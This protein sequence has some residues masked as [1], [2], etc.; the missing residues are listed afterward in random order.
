MEQLPALGTAIS[1]VAPNTFAIY[2]PLLVKNGSAITSTPRKSF[3][4]GPHPRQELDVY[5][6][7]LSAT[8]NDSF[9]SPILIFFY[10]GGFVRGSKIIPDYAQGLVHANIGHFFASKYRYTTVIADYR[11]ISHG[12]KYPSGGEDVALVI[13]WVSK[14][15]ASDEKRPARPKDLFVMGNSAGGVHLS[16]WLFSRHFEQSR[17]SVM[18]AN[19][20]LIA[21]TGVVWLSVPFHFR[22]AL[23][24]RA[25]TLETYYADF[26]DEHSPLGLL[27]AAQK[28]HRQRSQELLPGVS[29]LVLNGD[30]DP[31][32]EILHPKRDFVEAWENDQK[33]LTVDMMKGQNHI[34][35]A[36]SLGTDIE[37][38][39]AWGNQ[40]AKWMESVTRSNPK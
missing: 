27:K 29:V 8:N 3:S 28:Q 25:K 5:Y 20:S 32:D 31:D 26:V 2:Q 10:G 12:A 18:G 11:L 21:L 34:S 17:S 40:V 7:S 36:L 23:A 14:N 35:P 19:D 13:D 16:T 4:Y 30:L 6:P 38:E 39:E 37:H 15:L 24:G 33:T 9:S 22:Q 1:N